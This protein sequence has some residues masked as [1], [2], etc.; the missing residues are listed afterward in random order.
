MIENI[1][2]IIDE[3][4]YHTKTISDNTV[5]NQRIPA[6]NKQKT[7]LPSQ[8]RKHNT[9]FNTQQQISSVN[10]ETKSIK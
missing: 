5:K 2:Q 7:Y 6:R 10:W 9:T 8:R 4:A 3:E 1:S